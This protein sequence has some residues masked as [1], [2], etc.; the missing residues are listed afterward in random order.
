MY[1]RTV[2]C[3]GPECR[4]TWHWAL[5]DHNSTDLPISRTIKEHLK[6]L[7]QAVNRALL[8]MLAACGDVNRYVLRSNHYG[9]AGPAPLPSGMS[10]VRR[11]Q[12]YRVC[13]RKCMRSRRVSANTFCLGRLRIMRFGWTKKLVVGEVL[14]DFEP[15]YGEFYLPRKVCLF[16]LFFSL[17]VSDL[18]IVQDC[19]CSTPNQ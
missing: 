18:F 3:D 1:P 15:L 13:M 16:P 7:I 2:A 19:C 9:T 12:H 14:K 5:Q 11:F 10:S 4:R 8:D 6:P 17:S